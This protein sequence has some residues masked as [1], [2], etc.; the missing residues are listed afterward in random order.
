MN[1]FIR[2]LKKRNKVF[3]ITYLIGFITY[4]VT[5]IIMVNNILNLQ[6]IETT[7][8]IMLIILIYFFLFIYF[9]FGF[10]S[11]MDKRNK[12][13]IFLSIIT[14]LIIPIF[15]FSSIIIDDIVDRINS[16]NPEYITYKTVYISLKDT[17]INKD[18]K[19]GWIFLKSFFYVFKIFYFIDYSIFK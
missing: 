12:T 7:I 1:A 18:S 13:F 9:T 17:K 11:I 10:L 14:Y 19:I 4:L 3:L 2:K 15:I 16:L 5:S 6:G 8:R